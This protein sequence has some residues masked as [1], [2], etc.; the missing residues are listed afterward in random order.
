MQKW[1]IKI[2]VLFAEEIPRN[3]CLEIFSVTD[4]AQYKNSFGISAHAN[5]QI[6]RFHGNERQKESS[7]STA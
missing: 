6:S 7:I 1:N 5:N 4:F 2:G 3:F